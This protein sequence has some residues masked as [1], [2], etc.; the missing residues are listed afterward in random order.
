MFVPAEMREA[1]SDRAWLQ[2]MLDAERALA[3]AE[4]R[5]GLFPADAADAIAAWCHADLYDVDEIAERGRTVGDPA[6]PLVRALADAVGGEAG[7]YVHRGATSHDVLDTAAML[8]ARRALDLIVPELSGVA[9]GCA[10]LAD[11]HR[12]TLVAARTLLQQAPPTT[13]GL[14]AAGWLVAV[15]DARR[16]LADLRAH[17]LAAQLGGAAGTLAA[18]G[19]DGPA[20]LRLYAEELELAEPVIPWHSNRVRVAELGTALDVASGA[21]AKIALDVALLAQT[22][23]GEVAEP[24]RDG[25]ST[26]TQ[27]RN[28]VG[29]TLAAAC[30]RQVHA[31]AAVLSSALAQEHERGI[32]GWHAEWA[33]LTGALA[34][35][36]GAA[37]S[38]RRVVEGLEVDADRMRRNVD[39]M[40]ALLMAERISGVLADL[41]GRLEARVLVA[42]ASARAA[43]ADRTLHDEL[44]L[45]SRV[46]LTDDE[47]DAAFDTAQ[48]LGSA[49]MFVDRAL[50]LYRRETT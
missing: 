38:M 33:A 39:S 37:A 48:Y 44:R 23:V 3:V 45:D 4:A 35:T 41:L 49:E 31:H 14:K 28:P 24:A 21:L 36:G 7:A 18:L 12:S 34:L 20:V 6:E 47:L 11:A 16:R 50:E 13:F 27:E 25:T 9:A 32:G 30:A 43:E 8:V 17:G 10:A 2:A 1:V 15:L 26:P 40:L 29:S 19:E 5:A 22:E 42:E 46:E